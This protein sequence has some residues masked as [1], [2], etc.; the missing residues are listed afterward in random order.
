[1]YCWR[2]LNPVASRQILIQATLSSLHS[3]LCNT[4]RY[5]FTILRRKRDGGWYIYPYSSKRMRTLTTFTKT[6]RRVKKSS[7][8][9]YTMSFIQGQTLYKFGFFCIGIRFARYCGKM[10]S[11]HLFP[12]VDSMMVFHVL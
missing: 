2:G 7:H 6:N 8:L 9:A 4:V 11:H 3:W 5:I 12:V 1:M 10:Y